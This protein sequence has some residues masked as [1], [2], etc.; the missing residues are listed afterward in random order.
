MKDL[1]FDMVYL[2]MSY[3]LEFLG[4]FLSPLT[5]KRKDKY[6]G[7][8][9]NR[10][11][12]PIMVA[13]RIKQKCG[14]DFLIEA[15]ISGTEDHPDGYN[16]DDAIEYAKMFA[17]HIDLLQPRCGDHGQS[18][19]DNFLGPTPF[20]NLTEAIKKSGADIKVEA[21][22]GFTDLDI[23]EDTIASGKADLISMA[24]GWIANPT[25]GLLAYEGRGDDVVPCIRCGRC[26]I[27]SVTDSWTNACSVNPTYGLEHKIEKMI[28]PPKEKRKIAVIG[29]GPAGMEA[30]LVAASRGHNVTLYEKS[31][32]LGGLLKISDN[33]SFKWTLRD[34]KNYMKRQIAKSGIKVCLNTE[35][36]PDMLKAEGYDVILAALGSK[37]IVPDIP[38]V[39]SK[40]VVLAQDVYTKESTFAKEVVIIGGGEVGVETGIHLAEKG[41]Q[42]TVIEML[43][44]LA[45]DAIAGSHH[46]LMEAIGKSKNFKYILKARCNGIR[47]DKVSYVDA[48]G[49]EQTV[50]AG[51]VVI[52]V[53]YKPMNDFALKF[54]GVGKSCFII[55]DCNK[56]GNVQKAMRSAFGTASML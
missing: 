42:V 2:H 53:G 19:P 31:D 37:P 10:T 7:S 49:N 21:I 56:V 47:E 51:S 18:S 26:A 22:A 11:R 48:N 41:H 23:C 54:Y 35:A 3:R 44:I 38:G 9:E 46:Q 28:V 33:V 34:F 16:L 4:R 50:N 20:L 24:R 25:L 13:D 12:F 5:N 15:S 29:G 55:G 27:G 43:N 17:G 52:A 14:K 39:D 32:S 30:A 6:G 40:N 45:R 1:G 8:L 36:T